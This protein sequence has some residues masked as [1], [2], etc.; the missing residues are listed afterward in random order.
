MGGSIHKTLHNSNI[1]QNQKGLGLGS[2]H[3]KH[4]RVVMKVWCYFRFCLPSPIYAILYVNLLDLHIFFSI[5][6]SW[7]GELFVLNSSVEVLLIHDQPHFN[8]S[9][10]RAY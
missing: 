5:L 2:S 6:G 8:D 9:S 7:G 10:P 4:A 3:L 1:H